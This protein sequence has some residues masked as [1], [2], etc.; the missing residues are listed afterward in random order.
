MFCCVDRLDLKMNYI[1][2]HLKRDTPV[3]KSEL[4]PFAISVWVGL[5]PRL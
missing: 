2:I 1:Q 4:E 5:H 3:T